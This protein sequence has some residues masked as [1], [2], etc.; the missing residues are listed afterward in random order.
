MYNNQRSLKEWKT[1]EALMKKET[2]EDTKYLALLTQMETIVNSA[3]KANPTKSDGREG[4][5]MPGEAYSSWRYQNPNSK[6]TMQ[7]GNRTLK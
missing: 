6:K 3:G 2:K 5:N 1:K 7:K 4:K